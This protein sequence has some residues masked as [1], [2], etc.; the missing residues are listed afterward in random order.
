MSPQIIRVGGV[1]EH[2]NYPWALA[3]SKALFQNQDFDITWQ[4]YPG[5]TGAMA[6]DLRENAL[7]LALMLTEGAITDIIK[8][9]PSK[10]IGTYVASP[11]TW[12]VHV[13][14]NSS[15]QELSDV[16]NP[17]FAISRYRSGSHLMAFV[18]AQS[19]NWPLDTLQFEVVGNFKGAQEALGEGRAQLFMWEKFTT[20]PTVDSGEW[21][22]IAECPTPWPCFVLVARQEI[23]DNFTPQ[24]LKILEIIRESRQILDQTSTIEYISQ[25]YQLENSQVM[26]WYAQTQWLCEA[27]IEGNTLEN[28]QKILQDLQIIEHSASYS[29]LCSNFCQIL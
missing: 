9:N 7:D 6:R 8:G 3:I 20:Q 13:S 24:L 11:L 5:G 28:T 19:L 10:I 22:R 16:E 18:L 1:P 23:I 25:R 27:Q 29:D 17:T 14:A 26:E 12:G 2:F 15:Y 21:R 4:D